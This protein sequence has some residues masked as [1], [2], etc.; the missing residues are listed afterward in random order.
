MRK[1]SL[2][3]LLMGTGTLDRDDNEGKKKRSNISKKYV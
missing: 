2:V 1:R 3:V